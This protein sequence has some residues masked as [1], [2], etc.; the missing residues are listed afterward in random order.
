MFILL[1]KYVFSDFERP[2]MQ[3][4]DTRSTSG[5][6]QKSLEFSM[7]GGETY[8]K[9]HALVYHSTYICPSLLSWKEN[10]IFKE[11]VIFK[12]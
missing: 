4:V 7:K 5:V 2:Q 1:H 8:L 9:I 12:L 6:P 10:L 11:T 3:T